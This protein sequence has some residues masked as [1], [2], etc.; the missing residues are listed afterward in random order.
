MVL[1]LGYQLTFSTF[2]IRSNYAYL[3][4]FSAKLLQNGDTHN[5][6]FKGVNP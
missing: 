6:V 5:N 1:L 3:T 2:S 4:D